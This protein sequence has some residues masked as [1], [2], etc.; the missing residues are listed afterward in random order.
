MSQY[1]FA[2]RLLE[3]L[4]RERPAPPN[5]GGYRSETFVHTAH[6]DADLARLEFVA[7]AVDHRVFSDQIREPRA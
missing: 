7:W 3:A 1:G 5:R 2:D 6:L 4:A